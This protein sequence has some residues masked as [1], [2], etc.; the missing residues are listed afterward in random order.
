MNGR[1][2]GVAWNQWPDW[3]LQ[4]CQAGD[5]GDM[6][7]EGRRGE[8]MRERERERER[9]RVIKQLMMWMIVERR[10]SLGG[11]GERIGRKRKG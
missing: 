9:E 5:N 10:V 11:G 1:D 3:I 6:G 7:R 8:R 2:G 4:D